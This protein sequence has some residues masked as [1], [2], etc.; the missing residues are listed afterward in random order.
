MRSGSHTSEREN[1]RL[2]GLGV[3]SKVDDSLYWHHDEP[4]ASSSVRQRRLLLQSGQGQQMESSFK[5]R[6]EV[7]GHTHYR[8]I[9][10]IGGGKR[11][12]IS[13]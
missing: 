1:L 7:L 11:K 5:L 4:Q 12:L 8:S 2:P 9:S 13:A 6:K 3:F 10:Q